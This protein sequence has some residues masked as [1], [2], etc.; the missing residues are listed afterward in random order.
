LVVDVW[1]VAE[2]ELHV[3][4]LVLY[5]EKKEI[6]WKKFCFR[7]CALSKIQFYF[8]KE[9]VTEWN[10]FLWTRSFSEIKYFKAPK[11]T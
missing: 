3:S 9:L 2:V 1:L 11:S 8:K 5:L 4:G 6:L 10:L 7:I